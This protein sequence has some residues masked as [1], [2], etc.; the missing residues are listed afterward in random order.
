MV[1]WNLITPER[2][3][4]LLQ[5]LYEKGVQNFAVQ[6][7]RIQNCYNGDLENAELEPLLQ[8]RLFNKAGDMFEQFVVR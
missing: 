6:K 3:E 1:N 4:K 8:N 5:K 2:F 7:C